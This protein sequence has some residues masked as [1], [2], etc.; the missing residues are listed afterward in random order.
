MG[1]NGNNG[2]G[3]TY[4]AEQFIDAIPGTGGIISAIA[5]RVGC[6]W[7]TA[8][9]YIREMPTVAAAYADECESVTDLAETTVIKAIRDGDVGTARWYLST[10]GKNRGYGERLE[11]TGAEGKPIAIDAGI[12][13]ND[14]AEA[15]AILGGSNGCSGCGSS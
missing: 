11:V 1:G 13:A 5:K 4:R 8:Q 9:K 15:L 6:A 7:H 2:K 3:N 12:T 14:I 10:K